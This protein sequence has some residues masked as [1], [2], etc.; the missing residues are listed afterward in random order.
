VGEDASIENLIVYWPNGEAEAW[1]RI[2]V[3][4]IIT[5]RQGTGV[6]SRVKNSD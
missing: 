5:I 1:G 6:S 3:D 2:P 4:R